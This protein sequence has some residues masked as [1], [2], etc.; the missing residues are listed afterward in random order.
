MKRQYRPSA[1]PPGHAVRP[2]V[3]TGIA[4]DDPLSPQEQQLLGECESILRQCQQSFLVIGKVMAQFY[5]ALVAWQKAV[6]AAAGQTV[7]GK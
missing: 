5:P 1:T 3:E 4:R 7:T 6:A 2:P